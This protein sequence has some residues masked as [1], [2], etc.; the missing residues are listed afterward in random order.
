MSSGAPKPDQRL[1]RLKGFLG[2]R[3]ELARAVELAGPGRL[4]LVGGFLRDLL[5]ERIGEDR[6]G[7]LD[8]D[9]AV[10]S[11]ALDLGRQWAEAAGAR[12]VVLSEPEETV[13][14][15]WPDLSVDL[16][17]FRRPTLSADLAARDFTLNA[18]ALD[19]SS[20]LEDG[21]GPLP[22]VIDPTGGLADLAAGRLV[23]A[24]P[25]VM[26]DDPL[27]VLRGYR[28]SAELGLS[29]PPETRRAM[30]AA[31]PSLGRVAGERI[32]AELYRLL[33]A[34]DSSPRIRLM[35]ADGLLALV[36]PEVEGLRDVSQNRFHHLGGLEHTLLCLEM[37][38]DLLHGSEPDWEGL[39]RTRTEDRR[40]VAVKLA[41]L[42]H[43]AGKRET[44]TIKADGRL[45]FPGHD[46]R[47]AELWLV[48]AGRLRL[49]RWLSRPVALLI[50][51]HMRPLSLLRVPRPSPRALR[52][53]VLSAEGFL[54]ELGL[55]CLADS[56]ATRGPEKD[57]QAEA[58]LLDLWEGLLKTR[59]TLQ[60]QVQ[61]P[62]VRGNELMEAL[63][64]D[65]GPLIGQLLEGIEELRLAGR[66]RT[67]AEALSWAA[68]RVHPAG[69]KPDP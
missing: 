58:K 6:E 9:L 19:L 28:L 1:A 46:K 23:P 39:G 26:E 48:A 36:L 50:K 67:R 14:L 3:R 30:S 42:F 56:L 18:L 43:D 68:D 5:L 47:S 2:R 11:G 69:L 44:A 55:L 29:L 24:G 37:A 15:V 20:L 13:R 65:P 64:L 61:A 34:R 16:A 4:F 31:G 25:G 21:P 49:P 10:E 32:G 8:L 45:S 62:L 17:S 66:I 63:G 52:R 27:R 33:A 53:L 57:P 35:A 22:E 54:E 12:L 60:V 59:Q 51:A 41:A 40:R 7:T 38:E